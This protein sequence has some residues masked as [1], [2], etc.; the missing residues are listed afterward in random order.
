MLDALKSVIGGDPELAN[1]QAAVE[2]AEYELKRT[3]IKITKSKEKLVN[4][5]RKLINWKLQLQ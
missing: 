3:N 2:S 1:D 5:K 4:Y